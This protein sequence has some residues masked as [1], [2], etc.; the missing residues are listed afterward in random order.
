MAHYLQAEVILANI[1]LKRKCV[2]YKEIY[3]YCNDIKQAMHKSN[4]FREEYVYF[5]IDRDSIKLATLNYPDL[6]VS[7]NKKI[8]KYCDYNINYFNNRLDIR[9]QKLLTKEFHNV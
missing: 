8:Y 2:T 4:Q 6:F 3:L 1:L 5:E 9:L 7:I